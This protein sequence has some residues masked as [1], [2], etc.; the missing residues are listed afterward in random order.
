MSCLMS[1]KWVRPKSQA[2]VPVRS[3]EGRAGQGT[4]EGSS[5]VVD[6]A[7]R[8][9]SALPLHDALEDQL[10]VDSVLDSVEQGGRPRR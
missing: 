7:A 6:A 10:V 8:A 9:H 2:A 5:I 3:A 4:A 1:Q